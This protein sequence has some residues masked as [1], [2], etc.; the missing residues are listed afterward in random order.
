MNTN[1]TPVR[2]SSFLCVRIHTRLGTPGASQH[3]IF[4]SE[5]LITF[6]LVLMTG[7]ELGSC[8]GKS[9]ALPLEPPA[10][11]TDTNV[12][13]IP[14]PLKHEQAAADNGEKTPALAQTKVDIPI[15]DF[16]FFC[17]GDRM[18]KDITAN[19]IKAD[20]RHYCKIIINPEAPPP[21][22]AVSGLQTNQSV[23]GV[24]MSGWCPNLC[25]QCTLW[26]MCL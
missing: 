9:D 16:F 18:E 15:V 26:G 20:Y 19:L 2:T 24:R 1:H 12:W 25:I 7:F 13:T 14:M 6:F 3:N 21:P 10:R 11:P 23:R 8:N 5:K 17:S 4:D 22:P